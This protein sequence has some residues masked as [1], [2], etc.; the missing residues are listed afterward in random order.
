MSRGQAAALGLGLG[1]GTVGATCGE[2]G[3]GWRWLECTLELGCGGGRGGL[4]AA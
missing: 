3:A 1:K 4:A 2:E